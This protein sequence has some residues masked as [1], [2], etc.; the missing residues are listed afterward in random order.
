VAIITTGFEYLVDI[1][2]NR[3]GIVDIGGAGQ[4]CRVGEFR[5]EY[6]QDYQYNQQ[7]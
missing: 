2:R 3:K 4:R 7:R 5:P 1:C 6:L